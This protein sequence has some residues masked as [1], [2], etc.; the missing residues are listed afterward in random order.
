VVGDDWSPSDPRLLG[1]GLPAARPSGKPGPTDHFS[2]ERQ[3]VPMDYRNI[4]GKMIDGGAIYEPPAP[5]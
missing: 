3:G 2:A 5:E 1:S 4:L